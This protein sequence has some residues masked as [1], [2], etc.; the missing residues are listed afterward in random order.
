M[1]VMIAYKTDVG[2]LHA[3]GTLCNLDFMSGFMH[4]ISTDSRGDERMK[5]INTEYIVKVEWKEE[6]PEVMITDWTEML[7]HAEIHKKEHEKHHKLM[8]SENGVDAG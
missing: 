5:S 4:I 1:E 3:E 2:I 7:Y 6:M 8:D